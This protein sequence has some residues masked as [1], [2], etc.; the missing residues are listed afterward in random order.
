MKN[1][2]K[3][4]GERRTTLEKFAESVKEEP[5]KEEAKPLLVCST[6]FH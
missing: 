4:Y 1:L 2:K 6:H 5:S 3:G